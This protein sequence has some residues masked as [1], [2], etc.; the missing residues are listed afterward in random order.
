MRIIVMPFRDKEQW[1]IF[2]SYYNRKAGIEHQ[3]QEYSFS[4]PDFGSLNSFSNYWH[5]S[6]FP[7]SWL[8]CAAVNLARKKFGKNIPRDI[9]I[10]FCAETL[11]I[12]SQELERTLNWNANYMAWHDGG[13]PEEHHAY[14]DM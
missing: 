13:T 7:S 3:G 9:L 10:E 6:K 4:E 5:H 2:L 11:N 1:K 8:C 12:T 14:P